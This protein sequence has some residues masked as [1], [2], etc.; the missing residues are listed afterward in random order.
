MGFILWPRVTGRIQLICA[1]MCMVYSC[2]TD[3]K[4][5]DKCQNIRAIFIYA[6]KRFTLKRQRFNQRN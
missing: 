3:R 2:L 1:C 4:Q 5:I 6:C